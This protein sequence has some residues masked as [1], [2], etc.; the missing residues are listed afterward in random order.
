ML[1]KTGRGKLQFSLQTRVFLTLISLLLFVLVCFIIYV[2]LI[3]IKPLKSTTVHENLEAASKV[4]EQIDFYIDGQNQLSQRI[5]SSKDIFAILEKG[6][7]PALDAERFQ[8]TRKLK[9]IMFQA[10]GPSMN[11]KD[12]VIYDKQG[13]LFVS[14]LGSEGSSTSL[15]SFLDKPLA[16][17]QWGG[18][19]FLLTRQR[20]TL[21]FIRAIND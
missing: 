2:N 12:M 11:I 18:G 14:Y 15:Q 9:D 21:S 8:L 10:I 17:V 20:D 5:L 6:T 19:D 4:S 3:V 7:L 16:E 13:S 1:R